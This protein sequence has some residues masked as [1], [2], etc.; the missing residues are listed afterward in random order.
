MK[1]VLLL[2]SALLALEAS[3]LSQLFE[4]LKKQ[5]VTQVDEQLVQIMKLQKQ[6]VSDRFYPQISLFGSL[7]HYNSAT[8]L[9]PVPPTE[10]NTL[11]KSHEPLPFA[12]NIA[13]VGASALMPVYIQELFDLQKKME[14]LLQSARLKKELNIYKNEGVI[15]GS[16]ADLGYVK[17][18]QEALEATRRSL[19]KSYEDL[20]IKVQSGR[21]P[22]VALDKIASALD[23]IELKMQDIAQR[24]AQL[25]AA[26]SALTGLEV[27]GY[28]PIFQKA[29]LQKS[30]MFALLPLQARLKAQK[31]NLKAAKDRFVPKV[32]LEAKWSQNYAQKDVVFKKDVHRGYGDVALKVVLPLSKSNI[33]D[34]ELERTKVL[35]QETQIAKRRMEL[36]AQ[37]KALEEQL[38]L[39]DKKIAI[40]KRKVARQVDLLRYAKTAFSVGRLTEE[41]YLRYEDTLLQARADLAKAKAQKWHLLAG[42]AVLYGN[43]LER[44][45]E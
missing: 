33:T 17:R 23:S 6:K 43:D 5:P 9:R 37:A 7:E 39:S 21:T 29:S 13:R 42:L 44:I 20:K 38:A 26:I 24:Q 28:E 18:L 4:A 12:Q 8:N 3:P 25:K 40:A 36:Q 27:G 30:Q 35:E 14:Y 2:C 45:V 19:Q 34:T 16:Y 15:L 10:A 1:R 32:L 11:L 41:E 31:A 22:P